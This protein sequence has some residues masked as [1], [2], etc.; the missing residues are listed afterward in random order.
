M[1]R[2]ITVYNTAGGNERTIETAAVTYGELQSDL[3]RANVRFENLQAVVGETQN[4]LGS[5]QSILP[6]ED[7]TLFFF[8]QKVKSGGWDDDQEYDQEDNWCE[9]ANWP[10]N[11]I[12]EEDGSTIDDLRNV[13]WELETEQVES[14]EY[15]SERTLAWA[16]AQKAAA[17]SRLSAKVIERSSSTTTTRETT[18][19]PVEVRVDL[20]RQAE[21]IKQNM[22]LYD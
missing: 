8:P 10:Y 6:S 4:I 21:Q 19:D 5:T 17:L 18:K 20:H 12:D 9:E 16:Y 22:G 15:K 13:N 14:Y 1:T 2:R 7:F 3:I 11:L